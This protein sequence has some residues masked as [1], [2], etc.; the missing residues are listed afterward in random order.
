MTMSLELSEEQIAFFS[1]LK[2]LNSSQDNKDPLA[3]LRVKGWDHFE[4]LGLPNRKA[5][6]FQYVNLNK[7]YS[8]ELALSLSGSLVSIEEHILS[9]CKKS[10][11]VF[12]NGQLDLTLSNL[13]GLPEKVI[14]IPLK[15]ALKSFGSFINNQVAKHLQEEVDPFAAL[16]AAFIQKALFF[17]V[18]PSVVLDSPLQIIHVVQGDNQLISPRMEFFFGALSEAEIVTTI[19]HQNG[20]GNFFNSVTNFSLEEGAQIEYSR[21][22][23]TSESMGFHF[24]ATRAYLKKDSKLETVIAETGSDTFRD[25][26]KVILAGS[27]AEVHLN[28]VAMLKDRL[29]SHTHVLI[30]HQAPDCRS[31]QVFKNALDGFSKASFEGKIYVHKIAQ[32]TQAFQLNNNLILNDGAK[33]DSKPNLEIFADDVKASHGATFGSLDDEQLF[34]LRARGISEKE[35]KNL[36]IQGFCFEIVEKIKV[37]SLLSL[38]KEKATTYLK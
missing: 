18:P 27:N 19:V 15:E 24:D 11:I 30:E 32:K 22:L 5:E 23:F 2:E 14:A 38:A 36:L 37:P 1:R 6:V 7:L 25:D 33:C 26:Y 29:E 21:T 35:A 8:K 3:R 12:V 4:E 13:T 10:F 20:Q 17:Y 16:N 34:Y 31:L 9:E 28:G